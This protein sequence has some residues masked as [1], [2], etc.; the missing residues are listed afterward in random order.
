MPVPSSPPPPAAASPSEHSPAPTPVRAVYGF[1]FYL[2]GYSALAVYLLWAIVP[3][4]LLE[5][6]GILDVFPQK[7]W[8]VALPIY[9]GVTFFLFVTV[10]YPSL[11][12]C[13]TPDEDDIRNVVDPESKFV[14]E[15]R[16]QEIGD[17]RPEVLLKTVL[18]TSQHDVNIGGVSGGGSRR[19][20]YRAGHN[21]RRRKDVD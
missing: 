8:A 19:Q 13:V 3:D 14:S 20:D 11:G 9:L 16:G 21:R 4:H 1:V 18:K 15:P 10:V 7:Y 6:A 5:A 12:L 2:L 17:V